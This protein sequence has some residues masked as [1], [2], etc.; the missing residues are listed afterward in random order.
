MDTMLEKIVE[1]LQGLPPD[2]LRVV[3]QFVQSVVEQDKA[4]LRQESFETARATQPFSEFARELIE[5][6]GAG[7]PENALP[8]SDYAVSREGLYEDHL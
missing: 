8:L 3:S 6:V 4:L 2:K 1:Q 5:L 7:R